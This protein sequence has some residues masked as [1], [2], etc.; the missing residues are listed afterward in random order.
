M[1]KASTGSPKVSPKTSGPT[2]VE[3]LTAAKEGWGTTIR[4]A[5]LIFTSRIGGV[6]I[7]GGVTGIG[8][9]LARTRGWL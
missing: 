4:L 9:A 7:G 8:T 1:G 2:D 5:V 6:V 3:M